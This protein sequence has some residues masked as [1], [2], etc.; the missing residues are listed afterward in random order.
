MAQ[1][2]ASQMKLGAKVVSP[3]PGATLMQGDV[4][5]HLNGWH[6]CIS[7][8]P[9][10]VPIGGWPAGYSDDHVH[11][12]QGASY[13]GM[14]VPGSVNPS[15]GYDAAQTGYGTDGRAVSSDGTIG[16]APGA[17]AGGVS[18]QSSGSGNSGSGGGSPARG[19]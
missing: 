3:G 1:P 8:G 7:P 15:M 16:G 2:K 19:F 13:S 10:Y 12:S 17:A 18:G 5:P 9:V 14:G 11:W 6:V 4:F